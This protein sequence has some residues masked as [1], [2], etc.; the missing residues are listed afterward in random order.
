MLKGL[1]L[2]AV[3]ALLAACSGDGDIQVASVTGELTY[4]ERIA[5]PAGAEARVAL[6]MMP[7]ASMEPAGPGDIV[8]ET[9]MAIA[10][11]API[12]FQ[13]DVRT[14]DVDPRRP[15]LIDAWIFADD[16]VLFA[17]TEAPAIQIGSRAPLTL[18]L[19]RPRHV[20]YACSDGSR[21]IVAYPLMG[22]LAFLEAQGMTP[23]AMRIQPTGSGFAYSG[24]GY[25]L[26]GKGRELL[27]RRPSGSET[28]CQA[29][30]S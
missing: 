1:G 3:L 12:P 22:S 9:T 15:L 10:H 11:A 17:L 14:N 24:D 8:A 6:R 2:S 28:R 29:D 5:L 16:Q 13:I 7:A 20:A 23:V 19:R 21:P 18:T 30:Q 27:L 26:R 25:G 4:L